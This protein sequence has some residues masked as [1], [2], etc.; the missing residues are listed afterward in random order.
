MRL[1]HAFSSLR[2]SRSASAGKRIS[3]QLAPYTPAERRRLL[4]F[5]Q[6][7]HWRSM[8]A[9]GF[10]IGLSV[11]CWTLLVINLGLRHIPMHP[12]VGEWVRAQPAAAA[13]TCLFLFAL[14]ACGPLAGFCIRD[15]WLR[16]AIAQHA[17]ESCCFDCAYSLVDLPV[18]DDQRICPECG[19]V[20]IVVA[21]R[22]LIPAR[23]LGSHAANHAGTRDP[24]TS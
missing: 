4:R 7:R 22:G 20:E 10:F 2:A 1:R 23:I 9:T 6:R 11:A 13:G 24:L 16:W 3:V 21:A 15:H 8:L 19:E 12:S 5:V 18:D 17:G 14:L